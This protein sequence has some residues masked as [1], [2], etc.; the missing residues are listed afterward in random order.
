MEKMI[1]NKTLELLS[2]APKPQR[3]ASKEK[4]KRHSMVVIASFENN[5]NL[6]HQRKIKESIRA[7]KIEFETIKNEV[8]ALESDNLSKISDID[9]EIK[10]KKKEFFELSRQQMQYYLNLL[11]EGIDTRT[12]GISW[13]IKRLLEL[14]TH[15]EWKHFPRFLDPSQV[16]FLI[17]VS[18]MEIKINQKKIQM[19]SLKNKKKIN[20]QKKSDIPKTLKPDKH[21][22]ATIRSNFT[23]QKS[24]SEFYSTGYNT[25]DFDFKGKQSHFNPISTQREV[26]KVAFKSKMGLVSTKL[27]LRTNIMFES[28]EVSMST[29]N[30]TETNRRLEEMKIS[31]LIDKIKENYDEDKAVCV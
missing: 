3:K 20:R 8:L 21:M 27:S 14:R 23:Q 11:R 15:L 13:I 31:R 25:M 19:T 17:E 5:E 26:E 29:K 4:T 7:N 2:M 28:L 22:A 24:N 10:K 30:N 9:K 12:E 6:V 1:K 16:R 18:N